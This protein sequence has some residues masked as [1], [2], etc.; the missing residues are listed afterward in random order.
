MTGAQWLPVAGLEGRYEVSATG[1]VR[2]LLHGQPRALATSVGGNGYR[3]AYMSGGSGRRISRTVHS[4]VAAAFI[5][6][7]PEGLQIRHLDGH[8]L[9]NDV[10]NLRYGTASENQMDRVKHGRHPL[11][12]RTHCNYGHPFDADNTGTTCRGARFCRACRRVTEAARRAE[13]AR[14]RPAPAPRQ[15]VVRT[16]CP[17]GHPMSD[18]YV[19][20]TGPQAGRRNCKPCHDAR[21]RSYRTGY[22]PTSTQE[23]SR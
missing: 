13:A 15:P 7:R 4:L 19:L 18:A 5:G 6:P 9:N 11:A 12:V 14:L 2:S 23:T 3:Y 1:G 10:A 17:I 20:R 8:P 21:E 22:T 16:H